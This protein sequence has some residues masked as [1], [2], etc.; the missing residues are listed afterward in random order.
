MA[1][2]T[3]H[4]LIAKL[5]A[6]ALNHPA[7]IFALLRNVKPILAIKNFALVTRYEDIQEV[8]ARDDVFHVTYQ[9]KMEQV[10]TGENFF[11]GMQNSPQ[12]T[13]DVSLMRLAMRREDIANRIG[14]FVEAEA[15]RIMQ[16]ANGQIDVVAQLTRVVPTL[17]VEDYFGTPAPNRAAF[18]EAATLMFSYLFFPDDLG[19]TPRALAA[20]AETRAMLEQ[21]IT[22][23]KA[24]LAQGANPVDDVLGRCLALQASGTPGMDDVGIRNNLIGMLIGAIPTTSKC[25]VLCLEYLLS[26]PEQ[27]AAAQAAARADNDA[28]INQYV[29][30]SMRFN[31]FGPGLLR[32]CSEDYVLARGNWRATTIKAGTTV[33]VALQSAMLDGRKLAAPS[34]FRT[35]RPA[36]DYMHYGY[37]LHTCSGQYINQVQIAKIVKVVLKR[38]N[39]RRADGAAG[40]VQN[41]GAFPGNWVLQF[42]R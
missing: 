2:T 23:R 13:R 26:H 38:K 12:Y 19:L 3:P 11:L 33:F 27:L 37:G 25:A 42:D 36:Y 5:Q 15:E 4:P 8:L 16:A 34:Q 10:T 18:T 35:D 24:Q 30:E 7:L 20:A 14:P 1:Q 39:L 32:Y 28:L 22:T 40:Q 9:A 41:D 29:L 6:W 21:A 17:L 31:A